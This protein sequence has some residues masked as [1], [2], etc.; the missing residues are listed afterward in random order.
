M[1]WGRVAGDALDV[2]TLL[3]ALRPGNPRRVGA[4]AAMAVV[5]V[6]TGMD[7]AVAGRGDEG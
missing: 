1:V 5:L 4:A 6:A 2:A 7:L 3:P